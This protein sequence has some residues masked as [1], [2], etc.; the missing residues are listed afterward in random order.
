MAEFESKYKIKSADSESQ[1]QE[2]TYLKYSDENWSISDPSIDKILKDF[3]I[4]IK[5]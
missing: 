2:V 5:Q 3:N 1:I 4:A